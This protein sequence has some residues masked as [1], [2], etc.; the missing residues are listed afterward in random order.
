MK[1]D[2]DKTKEQLITELEEKR[3]RAPVTDRQ[4]KWRCRGGF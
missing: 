1:K 3:H 2:Q 4:R